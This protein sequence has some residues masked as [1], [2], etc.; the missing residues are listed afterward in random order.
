MIEIIITPFK[1]AS[2]FSIKNL[3]TPRKCVVVGVIRKIFEGDSLDAIL[4]VKKQYLQ[5][6]LHDNDHILI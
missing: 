2:I 3:M 4:H 6:T 5:I 1:I